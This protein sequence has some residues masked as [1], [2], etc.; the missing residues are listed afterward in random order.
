MALAKRG[1]FVAKSSANLPAVAVTVGG[2]YAQQQ[3]ATSRLTAQIEG[4]ALVDNSISAHRF[5]REVG[6]PKGLVVADP[7]RS[8]GNRFCRA[9]RNQRC[10]RLIASSAVS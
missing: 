7:S 5:S 9:L 6:Q 10:C 1:K 4:R 8:A 2:T 3:Q